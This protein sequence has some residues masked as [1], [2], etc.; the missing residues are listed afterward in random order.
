MTGLPV[1]VVFQMLRKFVLFKK[2]SIVPG[3]ISSK[4]QNTDKKASW[5]Y[6]IAFLVLVDFEKA[7]D[8][9]GNCNYLSELERALE[10]KLAD[11]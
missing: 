1:N 10:S 5:C 2:R 3:I 8:S 4:T 11:S 6:F 7:F 9:V